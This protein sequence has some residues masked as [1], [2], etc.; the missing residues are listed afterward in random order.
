MTQLA[1]IDLERRGDVVIAHVR[2]DIDLSNAGEI[3]QALESQATEAGL[4]VDLDETGY[5][6]SSGVAVL[7]AVAHELSVRRQRLLIVAPSRSAVRRVLEIVQIDTVT[8]VFTSVDDAAASL[9]R[10]EPG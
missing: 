1:R 7:V 3:R 6:D 10:P 5:I 2:G 8:D 4:I 9:E